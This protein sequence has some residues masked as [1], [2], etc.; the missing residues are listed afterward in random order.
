MNVKKSFVLCAVCILLAIS[1]HAM[2]ASTVQLELNGFIPDPEPSL[3]LNLEATDTASNLD[4][5]VT[6]YQGVGTLSAEQ[7][8]TS[9][10]VFVSSNNDFYLF[11][12]VQSSYSIPYTFRINGGPSFNSGSSGGLIAGPLAYNHSWVLSI[13]IEEPYSEGFPT[14]NYSDILTF[15]IEAN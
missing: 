13:N 14:G 12:T 2:G 1:F 3:S 15:T 10:N 7:D 11:H 9:Y 6:Y 4:L 8:D 5:R